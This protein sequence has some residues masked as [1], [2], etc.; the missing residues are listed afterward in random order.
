MNMTLLEN[1]LDHILLFYK[2]K[3]ET[4]TDIKTMVKLVYD[5]LFSE[6]KSI[7]INKKY[8]NIYWVKY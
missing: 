4:F 3:Y 2:L 8:K 1:L 5:L 7:V 6:Q